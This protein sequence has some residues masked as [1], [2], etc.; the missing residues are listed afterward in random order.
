VGGAGVSGYGDGVGSRVSVGTCVAASEDAGKEV[1]D[2][3]QPVTSKART[4]KLQC[5]FIKASPSQAYKRSKHFQR[6]RQN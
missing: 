3:L 5:S 2:I 6:S 4:I 1:T